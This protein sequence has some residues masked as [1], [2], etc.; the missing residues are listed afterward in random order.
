MEI[1][2]SI[3]APKSCAPP[4]TV[5]EGKGVCV[6]RPKHLQA[7]QTPRAYGGRMEQAEARRAEMRGELMR[8]V[9]AHHTLVRHLSNRKARRSS[10]AAMAQRKLDEAAERR[11]QRQKEEQVRRQRHA[12]RIEEARARRQQ[13]EAA[14]AESSKRVV[15]CYKLDAGAIEEANFAQ[16]Q[17]KLM[18]RQTVAHVQELLALISDKFD[19]LILEGKVPASEDTPVGASP[20]KDRDRQG[21]KL[22]E[23]PRA[24]LA[25]YICKDGLSEPGAAGEVPPLEQAVQDH[26]GELL[27]AMK[28][29]LAAL[30]AGKAEDEEKAMKEFA[31]RYATFDASFTAWKQEDKKELLEH[32]ISTYSEV[33]RGRVDVVA[34]TAMNGTRR[35]EQHAAFLNGVD[36]SLGSLRQ[37]IEHIGGAEGLAVLSER[38]QTLY[39]AA[40]PLTPQSSQGTPPRDRDATLTPDSSALR[41]GNSSFDAA[42]PLGPP[43]PSSASLSE[44]LQTLQLKARLA[45]DAVFDPDPLK[46]KVEARAAAEPSGASLAASLKQAASAAFWDVLQEELSEEP[47]RTA[48]LE[49]AV[50]TLKDALME[51]VPRKLKADVTRE[52]DDMLDFALLKTDLNVKTLRGV[53]TYFMRKVLEFE[54]PA[55]N[56]ATKAKLD[57]MLTRVDG[58]GTAPP[59]QVG[60]VVRDTLAAVHADLLDLA[61]DIH[62]A[63]KS[64]AAPLLVRE[65]ALIV[66]ALLDEELAAG[67]HGLERTAAWLRCT[68]TAVVPGAGICATFDKMYAAGVAPQVTAEVVTGR[69]SELYSAV[70]VL[71]VALWVLC[72]DAMGEL[73]ETLALHRDVLRGLADSAQAAVLTAAM[74]GV[75]GQLAGGAPAVAAVA[76]EVERLLDTPD[77]TLESLVDGVCEA[78]CGAASP[79]PAAPILPLLQGMLRKVVNPADT[80]Y[81]TY[82]VRLASLLH[83]RLFPSPDPAPAVSNTPFACCE[84]QVEELVSGVKKLAGVHMSWYRARYTDLVNQA[85]EGFDDDELL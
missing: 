12:Q 71:G 36:A 5:I 84:A 28:S 66:N 9:R 4:I 35:P 18:S 52:L 27:T 31:R 78:A 2:H 64:L 19:R 16:M 74:A 55:K 37:Q 7:R 15:S 62:L 45:H 77:V 49:P 83:R 76:K 58:L 82:H 65:S 14:H 21:L 11:V 3:V 1:S 79:P 60:A 68:L 30:E 6:W 57:A 40:L 43:T 69:G 75:A 24:F 63:R 34:Q 8:R 13:N 38:L 59:A 47:S 72:P 61:D 73:P 25:A 80:V 53:T 56:D 41:S 33:E 23:N 48:R 46:A 50:S 20:M 17:R 81:A 32:Y 26:A 10:K 39:D 67:E 29:L 85:A 54:A 51:V 70:P 22:P 42:W 44:K